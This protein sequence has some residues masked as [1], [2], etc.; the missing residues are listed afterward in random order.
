L[1]WKWYDT[2][3]ARY[4][5]TTVYVGEDGIVPNVAYKCVKGKVERVSE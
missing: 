1:T 5:L 2:I 4:H 3:K